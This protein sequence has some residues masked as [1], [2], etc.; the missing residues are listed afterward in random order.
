[1]R[2]SPS[3]KADARWYLGVRCLQCL[4]PILFAV[5]HGGAP[6]EFMPSSRKLVLTCSAE[7]CRHRADYT[8]EKV[9]RF[10]K[11]QASEIEKNHDPGKDRKQKSRA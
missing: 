6:Q 9:L 8:A 5:D 7:K 3:A 2:F 10:Q 11:T 1:M 4:A